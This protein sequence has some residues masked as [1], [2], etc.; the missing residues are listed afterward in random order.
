[1]VRKS[2]ISMQ[3]RR[4]SVSEELLHCVCKQFGY[5]TRRS[6]LNLFLI[7]CQLLVELAGPAS[8]ALLQC[9]DFP[10]DTSSGLCLRKCSLRASACAR[11][12]PNNTANA[13]HRD[14]RYKVTEPKNNQ[15]HGT[16]RHRERTHRET[17][18][19]DMVLLNAHPGD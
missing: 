19:T 5:V 8:P 2:T 10:I 1:M 3:H 16:W 18:G 4:R 6:C 12:K 14:R 15:T 9:R 11:V 7:L 13:S 17:V